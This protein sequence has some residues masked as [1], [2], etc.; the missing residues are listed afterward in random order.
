MLVTRCHIECT[1]KHDNYK[2]HE[3]F[4]LICSVDGKFTETVHGKSSY[5]GLFRNWV[6]FHLY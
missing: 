3:V 2:T 5:F 4:N 1:R 6:L